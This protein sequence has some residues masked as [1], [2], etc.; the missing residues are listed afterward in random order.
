MA[1]PAADVDITSA[2]D[3]TTA[4]APAPWWARAGAFGVDVLPG[5]AV[6][7]T[8]ALAALT[9]PLRGVWWWSCVSVGGVAM[10][11]TAGNRLLAPAITGWS[12]GRGVFSIAVQRPV[13]ASIS[14]VSP[15]RLL[16]R[17]LAHLLDTASVFVGWLWPLW[18]ARRRTFADML[19]GTVVRRV[20][21]DRRP[22]N[23]RRLTAVVFLTAALVCVAGATVSYLA[24]YQH[25]RAIGQARAQ[26]ASQGP[27]IVEQMLTYDPK[28]LRDDFAHAQ[29]L[30]TDKY[31]EQLV[32]QQQEVQKTK[33]VTNEY[34]V[35]TARYSPRHAIVPRCCCSCRASGARSASSGS[36]AP[37]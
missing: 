19:V 31:R 37:R 2:A 30:A 35:T 25:D 16:V 3:Q 26:I 20:E 33:P 22:R 23:I 6:V 9:V 27:K 17:D 32:V 36:S 12:L 14:S 34:W 13:G 24:V 28:S 4:T 15:F 5:L 1:L 29:S 7:A 10:L 8:M 11:L 21:T 18:D